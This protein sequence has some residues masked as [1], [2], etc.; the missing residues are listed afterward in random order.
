MDNARKKELVREYKEQKAQPGIFA[1]R[2][3]ASGQ[4]WV[5]K[6]PDLGKR[7][8]GLWFQLGMGG[9]PGKSLQDAWKT[10][11]EAAFAFEI[12]EEI[13][14]DNELMIPVLLKE[15]EAYWR[16]ELKADALI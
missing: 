3:A 5:A 10:H 7:Q 16:Q 11:G 2:C 6:A 13:K 4:V 8:S 9:F 12:L 15:R 1:V 14:D